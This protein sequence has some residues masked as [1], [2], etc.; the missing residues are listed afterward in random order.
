MEMETK[1]EVEAVTRGSNNEVEATMEMESNNGS[2][3]NN[4]RKQQW[5]RKQHE[6]RVPTV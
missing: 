4:K 5:K 3:S 2:E 1:M 6:K